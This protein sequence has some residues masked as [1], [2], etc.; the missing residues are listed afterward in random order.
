MKRK[1]VYLLLLTGLLTACQSPEVG[2]LPVEVIERQGV[3][4]HVD[5]L[6][7]AYYPDTSDLHVEALEEDLNGDGGLELLVA[8]GPKKKPFQGQ[9][10]STLYVLKTGEVVARIQEVHEMDNFK[11]LTLEGGLEKVIYCGYSQGDGG[12]GLGLYRLEG[13]DLSRLLYKEAEAGKGDY[14]LIM[15]PEEGILEGY[16]ENLWG[17][18]VFMYETFGT[19]MWNGQDFEMT[20]ASVDTGPYEKNPQDLVVQYLSLTQINNPWTLGV[21][22]RLKD[23][24]PNGPETPDFHDLE[25]DLR[26]HMQGIEGSLSL[27][28]NL[29]GNLGHVILESGPGSP[30]DYTY[31]FQVFKDRQWHIKSISK[32]P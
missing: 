19:Y 4:D 14:E 11:V 27:K 23:L 12:H 30:Y 9:R 7:R 22:D 8:V 18:K 10:Y 15:S 2:T 29:E 16:T 31:T 26:M 32:R 21:K 13:Q 24:Y 1:G 20:F 25:E 5:D 3:E 17:A 6:V 28:A